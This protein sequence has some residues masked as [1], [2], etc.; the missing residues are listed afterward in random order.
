M[1]RSGTLPHNSFWGGGRGV[2]TYMG[3]NAKNKTMVK[4]PQRKK[5]ASKKDVMS[6]KVASAATSTRDVSQ[7]R[8]IGELDILLTTFRPAESTKDETK[9]VVY[10][11]EFINFQVLFQHKYYSSNNTHFLS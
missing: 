4:F 3:Q 8:L 5:T 7:I 9:E 11:I 1:G 10:Q 2:Q 6:S